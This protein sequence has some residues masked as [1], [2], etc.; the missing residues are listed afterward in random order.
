MNPG[1]RSYLEHLE[2]DLSSHVLR[3][4]KEVSPRFEIPAILQQVELRKRQPVLI[5]ERVRSVNGGLSEL[6]VVINLFGSR[7]RLADAIG[8]T[9]ERLPLD[10]IAREKPVSPVLIGRDR[11]AVKEVVQTGDHIDLFDLPIVTH[12]EMDQGPY[13]TSGSAWVKDPE[14]GQVKKIVT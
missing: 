5:F 13:L 4:T 6:P 12:H 10:Y 1:L 2:R 3:I 14:T 9:V 11:A 7:A 8:S